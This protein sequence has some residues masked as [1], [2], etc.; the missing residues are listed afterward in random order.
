MKKAAGRICEACRKV[1]ELKNAE[2]ESR[3]FMRDTLAPLIT[4]RTAVY[5]E[6]KRT[7]FKG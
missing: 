4:P 2:R 1:L 5:E 6:L 7:I 3:A